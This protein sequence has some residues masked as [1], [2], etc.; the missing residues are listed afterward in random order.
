MIGV[1]LG[2]DVQDRVNAYRDN[3]AAL[4]QRYMQSQEL[5]DLLAM[6]KMKSEKEAYAR[7][8]QMKIEN[9]PATIAQQYEAELT[10]RTKNDVLKGIS[11][12]LQNKQAMAQK[13]ID[14]VASKGIAGQQASNMLKL[15]EGGVI[16]FADEGS[17][18]KNREEQIRILRNKYSANLISKEEY[19]KEA[20]EIRSKGPQGPI[21]QRSAKKSDDLFF[22]TTKNRQDDPDRSTISNKSTQSLNPAINFEK[23]VDDKT[24]E[25]MPVGI[26]ALNAEVDSFEGVGLGKLPAPNFGVAKGDDIDPA[27]TP[28][29]K[30]TPEIKEK[31]IVPEV[32]SVQPEQR[33]DLSGIGAVAYEAPDYSKLSLND[34]VKQAIKAQLEEDPQKAVDFQARTPAEQ[35]MIDKLLKERMDL[36]SSITDPDKLSTD[37]L[38]SGL[39]AG[40]S[41]TPGGAFRNLGRG[42]LGA[43]QLQEKVKRDELGAINKMFLA[44]A[45]KQQKIKGDAF[46]KAQ[47]VRKSATTAGGNLLANEQARVQGDAKGFFDAS[48]ANQTA[49]IKKAEIKSKEFVSQQNNKVRIDISNMEKSINEQ[50][51]KVQRE[52]NQIK[53]TQ[54]EI[55]AARHIL[56]NMETIINGAQKNITAAYDKQIK[57]LDNPLGAGKGL[58][59]AEIANKKAQLEKQKQQAIA[60]RVADL[61]IDADYARKIILGRVST[62]SGKKTSNMDEVDKILGI[63]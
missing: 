29:T 4:Q 40:P 12:V 58:E 32:K 28:K 17:V 59:P 9:K 1:N 38:L 56:N 31:P 30:I 19:L 20:A 27:I 48:K 8:M 6:Q 3:P 47:D 55:D 63:K 24:G 10:G 61:K 54:G 62:K 33:T 2:S 25:N 52:A 23:P 41:S 7:D 36:R 26:Q 51:I 11:G 34:P 39:L 60:D 57:E 43:E 35:A 5:I 49:A 15:A 45:D 21:A 16:G 50:K 22:A 37:A 46:S 13:N 18:P 14:R 44:E 53:K 42:I